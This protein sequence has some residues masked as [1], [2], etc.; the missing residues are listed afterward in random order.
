MYTASVYASLISLLTFVPAEQLQGKRIS[1]FSYG[2]GLASTLFSLTVK[3]DISP[4]V[5]A[6]DF[7]A[8]LDDRSTET[9][10]DYEAATDLREKAHLKKNFEPQGDIKHIKSGVYYLTNI[11][12]MFRRKYEIKQ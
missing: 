12:D 7:K 6:C 10:V 1:L 2:S 9:P 5:K 3:G 11:D 4:I 8:K